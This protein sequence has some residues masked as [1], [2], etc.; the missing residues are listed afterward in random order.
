MTTNT[1]SSAAQVDML[2]GPLLGKILRFALPFA[3]ASVLEQLFNSIDIAV[4]GHFASSDALAAVGANTFLINL[5][6][7]LFVGIS[8]GANVVIANYIGRREMAGVRRAVATTIGLSLISGLVLLVVGLLI[9]RPVLT[10]MGTPGNILDDAVLYLRVYLLSS[11]FFMLYNFGASILRA[12]GDT[13]RPLYILIIAGIIKTLLNLLLVIVFHMGVAGVAL[14]TGVGYVFCS[15]V[16]LRLLSH[17]EAAFRVSLRS[18][19]LYNK[20]VKRILQIGIPAGLQGMTFSFSNVFV[21]SSINGYGSAVVAGASLS[22]TFDAYCYFLMSAFSGAAVTFVGQN[23]GAGN[24]AR[25][26]R[27]FWICLAGGWAS[28]LAGNLLFYVFR[29]PVL[30]L[31]TS[32]AEVVRYAVLRLTYATL[33]QSIA[34]FYE[35]PAATMR[36]FGHSLQPALITIFGTCVLRLC[37]VFFIAPAWPGFNHLMMIYPVTWV[38]TSIFMLT[39]FVVVSRRAYRVIF[40]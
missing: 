24:A 32:D 13:R 30:S 36:G 18:I 37:W 40:C 27:V 38:L 21:Q 23:Y 22:Q 19:R 33:L 16:I 26:R 17:E 9:S 6:I 29:Y 12:K 35:V 28:C 10:L 31:F 8:I 15:V 1:H 14:A 11:P 2:H 3:A 4:V 25:C 20:E 5:M 39:M 7:N 34:A